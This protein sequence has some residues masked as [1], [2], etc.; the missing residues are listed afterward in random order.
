M[1]LYF[2]LAL[3]FVRSRNI[4]DGL[5]RTRYQVPSARYLT[6]AGRHRSLV[7]VVVV[8]VVVAVGVADVVAGGTNPEN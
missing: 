5:M 1:V 4:L 8:V 3:V 2:M 7:V 6:A